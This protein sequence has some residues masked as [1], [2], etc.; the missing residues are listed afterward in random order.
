LLRVAFLV[1]GTF[2]SAMGVR[3]RSFASRLKGRWTIGIC[4]RQGGKISGARY[5]W[6]WLLA[7][8]PDLC[9]VFDMAA[10]GVLAG[11]AYRWLRGVPLIVDTGDAIF[12]L[13]RTA[14][15]RGLWGLSLTWLLERFALAVATLVITRSHFHQT[16]LRQRGIRAVAIPDGVDTRQFCPRPNP[17]LRRSL[18]LAGSLTVGM[19]G[20]I[21]WNPKLGTCYGM[22]LL[23]CL[24]LLRGRPVKGLIVGDG[25]GLSRLKSRC[26]ELQ[27]Q[28]DVVFLGRVPYEELPAI[29]SAMDIGLS[30]QTNNLVGQVRTTGK[31]PLY[32]ACGCYILSSDVGEASRI[33]PSEMKVPFKGT[34]DDGYPKRL[35]ARISELLD[36]PQLVDRAADMVALA[37][38]HFSYDALAVALAE[39]VEQCQSP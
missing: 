13:A 21:S 24:S 17:E 8:Q 30:T 10:A 36:R 12:E 15:A 20:S 16:Y 23:D 38:S 22:E 28:D 25:D 26:A 31:L 3:A 39:A 18:G 14:G 4:Y 27:L 33:L 34:R 35:A 1:N 29:L 32:L 19:L 7:E 11:G 2:D 9:Y 5:F 6:K 37:E